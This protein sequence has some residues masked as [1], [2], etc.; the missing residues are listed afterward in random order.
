MIVLFPK[1]FLRIHRS[2][3]INTKKIIDVKVETKSRNLKMDLKLT[4]GKWY[5]VSKTYQKKI[6]LY[7]NNIAKRQ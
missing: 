6:Q 3:I 5:P 1:I 4:N 2:T 7:L